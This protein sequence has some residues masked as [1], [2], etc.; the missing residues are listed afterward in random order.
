MAS[1]RCLAR[2]L[3]SLCS[4][5]PT[6]EEGCCYNEGRLRQLLEQKGREETTRMMAYLYL[7]GVV[8]R[9]NNIYTS[10]QLDWAAQ[11]QG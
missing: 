8:V 3:R 2:G 4:G 9:D 1:I 6:A 11:G 7:L 5:Q 10:F